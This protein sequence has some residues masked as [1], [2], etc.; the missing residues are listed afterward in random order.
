MVLTAPGR[1]CKPGDLHIHFF[2]T[3]TLSF[4]DGA[5]AQPS[6]PA[7]NISFG[8]GGERTGRWGAEIRTQVGDTFEIEAAPFVKP[9]RNTIAE[10][11]YVAPEL[12]TLCKD[13]GAFS[14][15]SR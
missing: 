2:G 4:T 7:E 5:P 14:I 3:A 12:E 11:D 8:S 1:F 15:W 13:R 9:L 10:D 6:V